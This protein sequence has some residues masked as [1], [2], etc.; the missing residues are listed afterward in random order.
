VLYVPLPVDVLM[1][2]DNEPEIE[3]YTST[4]PSILLLES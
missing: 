2:P 4:T 3:L 1:F